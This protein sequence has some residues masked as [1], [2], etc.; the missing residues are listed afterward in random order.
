MTETKRSNQPEAKQQYK[1]THLRFSLK[2]S[3]K[4]FQILSIVTL[5]LAISACTSSPSHLTTVSVSSQ[6]QLS[7]PSP[8]TC[9]QGPTCCPPSV[10]GVNYFGNLIYGYDSYAK[11]ELYLDAYIPSGITSPVPAVIVVHGGDF[12]AGSKCSNN[13]EAAYMAQNGLA[14]FTINY[15]LATSTFHT[16]Q[17]VPS[18]V[19]T[20]VSWIRQNDQSFNIN[21]SKIALWGTSAGA[22]IAMNAANEAVINNPSSAVEAVAGWSGVYDF[23]TEYYADSSSQPGLMT[24]AYDYLGCNNMTDQK[25]FQTLLTASP[26]T[27][28]TSSDPPALFATSTDSG[29][30]VGHCEVVNPQNTIEMSTAYSTHGVSSTIQTTSVC[31]HAIA[32]AY[33][34]IDPPG[35]GTMIANTTTWLLNTLNSPPSNPA[36]TPLPSPISGPTVPT[37]TSNCPPPT[38]SNVN[39]ISNLVYGTDFNSPVYL[40]A[41]LPTN[42]SST[43]PAVVLVHGGGHVSG[44][45]CDVSTEATALAQAGLAAFSVNYP[46]ATSTQPTFPNDVYDVMNAVSWIRSNASKYNILPTEIGIWGGS[47][48]GNLALSS[49]FAAN[50]LQNSSTVQAAVS[51]SGTAD[52]F[53]LI[54]EY[55][56]ASSGFNLSTSSWAQ[57]LGCSDPWSQIWSATSNSCLIQ[58]EEASPAQL[59]NVSPPAPHVAP[60]VL[61]VGSTDFTGLGTCEIVPINQQEEVNFKANF[62]GLI[63]QFDSNSLCAHA[64]AYESTEFPSTL[65]FLQEHLISSQTSNFTPLIPKRICDTRPNNPSNLTGQMA[66]C[67]SH[68]LGSNTTLS[69]QVSGLDSI[70]A[71]ATSVVI[72]LTATNATGNSY[73]T[74]WPDGQTMPLASTLNFVSD[75]TVANETTLQLGL[76]GAIDIYN[77]SGN[78]DVIVDIEGYYS[79]ASLGAFIPVPPARIADSRCGSSPS[80]PFCTTENIPSQNASLTTF[81]SN[82]S[83]SITVA[84]VAGIPTSHVTAVVLNV[85]VTNPKSWSY[86]TIWPTGSNQPVVSNINFTANETIANNVI[87][88]IGSLNSVQIYNPFGSTDVVVDVG[89]YFTNSSGGSSYIS[90]IP[91]RL[92][93]TRITNQTL[94]PNGSLTLKINGE[95]GISTFGVSAVILNITV[96][97]TTASSYLTIFPTTAPV[98]PTSSI[99]WSAGQ[100]IANMVIAPVDTSGSI[101]IA[102]SFGNADVIVDVEGSF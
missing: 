96:T 57:Y 55:Q 18:D 90:S 86:L 84:G 102:N 32:Y 71:Q 79:P 46:L 13:S 67:N 27:H 69:V 38:G 22:A 89:G 70:P 99:N 2:S 52:T 88:S 100:T 56:Q 94:A 1:L 58:F 7:L 33:D 72:N 12:I 50:L 82:T 76:D 93:D 80:Q 48:G 61:A 15:P 26:I 14:A 62:D 92:L 65:S 5:V 20:A 31:A 43:V 60:A 16:Y 101:V 42:T 66:Q 36:P 77:Y 59:M 19:M 47:A 4:R 98:P 74:A 29:Q 53:E 75:E 35:S 49:A 95:D 51:W 25:C 23:I 39:Y 85:T 78:V 17:D 40:D 37:N 81:G 97:N 44:D 64:F 30:G 41:Y 34:S 91:F 24:G 87:V 73:L 68:T 21:S 28:V 3:I 6:T 8:G 63:S 83:K 9:N 10:S 54:G 45:K 11:Q